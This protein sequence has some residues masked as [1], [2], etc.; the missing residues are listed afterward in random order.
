MNC[1][2]SPNTFDCYNGFTV[3]DVLGILAARAILTLWRNMINET[4]W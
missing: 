1:I 3:R 2:N 4:V